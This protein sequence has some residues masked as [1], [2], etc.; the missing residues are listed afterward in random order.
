[1]RRRKEE[2]KALLQAGSSAYSMVPVSDEAA[3]SNGEVK[4]DRMSM[5]FAAN[6]PKP[7]DAA[8]AGAGGVQVN[9]T[10]LLMPQQAAQQG[11]PQAYPQYS[12]G[13]P[14]QI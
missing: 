14:H 9:A 12:Q 5:M 3:A 7:Q 8:G 4:F 10:P 2:Q 11:S 1:M 6:D 13:Y